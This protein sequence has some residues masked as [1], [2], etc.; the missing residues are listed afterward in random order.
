M[1]P[2]IE[3]S[4]YLTPQSPP[5]G[6]RLKDRPEDFLVEELPL[7]EPCGEG[8]HLYLFLE[9]RNLSTTQLIAAVA[10]HF[11]VRPG[12]VGYAG[13]KDKRAVTRQLLSVHLPGKHESDFPAFEQ[14]RITLLW[15]DRHTNKLRPGHLAGNRFIIR[16]RGVDASKVVH[17]HRILRQLE[18]TGVPNRAGEQRFGYL[19]LNHEIGRALLLGEHRAALDLLLGPCDAASPWQSEPRALYAEHR[20]D[21]ARELFPRTARTERRALAALAKGDGP[22]RAIDGMDQLQR[23]YYITAFQSA[24]FNAVLDDRLAAGALA[25]LEEGDLAWKHDNGAV[26]AVTAG[27]D[28]AQ[29]AARLAALEI[30]PSGPMWGSGM[31]RAAGAVG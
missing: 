16:I 13:L 10:R 11:N 21:E 24:V 29:L 14:D 17:A 27:D 15:T 7:Y 5:V 28:P 12:D 2:R 31:T 22:K 8:E 18:T 6:G 20:Y 1:N 19:A 9:K 3:P 25:T 23:R 30:S 4:V 26:F